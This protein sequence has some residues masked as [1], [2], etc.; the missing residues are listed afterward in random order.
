MH[1]TAMHFNSHVSPSPW[2]RWSSASDCARNPIHHVVPSWRSKESMDPFVLREIWSS[3]LRHM[4]TRTLARAFFHRCLTRCGMFCSEGRSLVWRSKLNN[5]VP[6]FFKISL[7]FAAPSLR[8]KI[9]WTALTKQL[10]NTVLQQRSIFTDDLTRRNR[11]VATHNFC[12]TTADAIY[13]SVSCDLWC[14]CC[15]NA[16]K[17]PQSTSKVVMCCSPG[18]VSVCFCDIPSSFLSLWIPL[19]SSGFSRS[20]SCGTRSLPNF[21]SDCNPNHTLPM[22]LVKLSS[23]S[24]QIVQNG[25]ERE[26]EGLVHWAPTDEVFHGITSFP[27]VFVG[28]PPNFNTEITR[29]SGNWWPQNPPLWQSRSICQSAATLGDLPWLIMT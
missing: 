16:I 3:T 23:I 8:K 27:T 29:G 11:R 14:I 7:D 26:K 24:T 10:S 17:C 12:C 20:M 25:G 6:T 5:W 18:P 19:G 2:W 21:N 28:V 1:S 13:E 9:I 15:E 4:E 22:Q